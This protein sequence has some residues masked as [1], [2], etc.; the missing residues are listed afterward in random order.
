MIGGLFKLV[1]DRLFSPFNALGAR[2]GLRKIH[3]NLFELGVACASGCAYAVAWIPAGWVL[4][5][6]HGFLDYYDG[7]TRRT[8]LRDMHDY[9]F[10]GWDTHIVADKASEVAIFIGLAIGGIVPAWIAAIALASSLGVTVFGQALKRKGLV[11]LRRSMFDRAARFIAIAVLGIHMDYTVALIVVCG[12]NGAIF[13]QRA[14]E[15]VRVKN[16]D[17]GKTG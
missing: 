16:A 15:L 13:V 6:V 10:L 14:V 9:R 7:G 8:G 2:I 17:S 11:N 12:M 1:C 4:L 3:I 5:I